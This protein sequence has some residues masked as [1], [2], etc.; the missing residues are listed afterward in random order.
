M[1]ERTLTA[2]LAIIKVNNQVVGKCSS[3]NATET[4]RRGDVRGLGRMTSEE[5][6]VVG[7]DGSLSVGFYTIDMKK[8]GNVASKHFGVNRESGSL[9]KFINTVLL[10]D[11]GVDIYVYKKD[12]EVVDSA[13]GLVTSYEDGDFAVFEKCLMDNMSISITE[14]NVSGQNASFT[15]LNPVTFPEAQA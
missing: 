6:P 7:W 5:K 3:L 2:P 11:I 10:N 8:L 4:F 1:A 13:T 14:G 9:K 12:A 15:Y